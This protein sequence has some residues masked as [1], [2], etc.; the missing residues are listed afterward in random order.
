MECADSLNQQERVSRV[1]Q[2]EKGTFEH[3]EQQN[4]F[5]TLD[6]IFSTQGLALGKADELDLGG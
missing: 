4:A 2:Q 3:E 1:T 5:Y 6:N